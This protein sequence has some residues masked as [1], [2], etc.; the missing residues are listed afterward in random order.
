MSPQL[1]CTP[2]HTHVCT[3]TRINKH[4]YTRLQLHHDSW[5]VG[6][7]WGSGVV[8][9][10]TKRAHCGQ[11]TRPQRVLHFRWLFMVNK[12]RPCV[13]VWVCARCSHKSKNQWKLN[14][15]N[16]NNNKT[17]CCCCWE[18][19]ANVFMLQFCT[20]ATPCG[21]ASAD[22]APHWLL[23]QISFS[24]WGW[25]LCQQMQKIEQWM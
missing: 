2:T 11:E 1:K 16:C 9:G 4:S 3:P 22:S 18:V 23:G 5:L 24:H 17:C 20:F 12:R 25:K 21:S 10:V 8:R 7:G 14:N 19:S 13:C 6:W 15:N